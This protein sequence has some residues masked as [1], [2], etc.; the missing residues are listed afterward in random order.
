MQYSK[1]YRDTITEV[2]QLSGRALVAYDN[3][4]RD[5]FWPRRVVKFILGPF[6]NQKVLQLQ[7]GDNGNVVGFV[8]RMAAEAMEE[9]AVVPDACAPP[10]VLEALAPSDAPTDGADSGSVWTLASSDDRSVV[11]ELSDAAT[12]T[13]EVVAE[14]PVGTR[15][16]VAM[17]AEEVSLLNLSNHKKWLASQSASMA[18]E[19]KTMF[20][21]HDYNARNEPFIMNQMV[22]IFEA[23]RTKG[24][25]KDVR[26]RDKHT[27]IER[28]VALTSFYTP[29]EVLRRQ[30]VQSSVA[31][32]SDRLYHGTWTA[33]AP[34]NGGVLSWAGLRHRVTRGAG[35]P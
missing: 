25:Y 31:Q 23:R 19:F 21:G 17:S 26:L 9:L 32:T 1:T 33:M 35:A 4:A 22:R 8:E 30:L 18:V 15:S 27:L 14:Q 29:E 20:P 11:F 12:T 28:A 10:A 34:H 13:G 2:S 3:Q 7:A 5:G 24:E 16:L 6:F